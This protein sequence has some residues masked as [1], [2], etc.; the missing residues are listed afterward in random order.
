MPHIPAL[1]ARHKQRVAESF[2]NMARISLRAST[3]YCSLWIFLSWLQVV[4][5]VRE[6][7]T[8]VRSVV[9]EWFLSYFSLRIH[10]VVYFVRYRFMA[11]LHASLNSRQHFA[12]TL[13]GPR[14]FRGLLIQGRSNGT[15][16]A[17]S[18]KI[19]NALTKLSACNPH[20]VRALCMQMYRNA[21]CSI[22][23]V[24]IDWRGGNDEVFN[25]FL[26]ILFIY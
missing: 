11:N 13:Y 17:G 14:V 15:N 24:R 26:N 1:M 10:A 6:K 16:P 4:D 21:A 25:L 5:I 23:I 2:P 22:A 12:V 19:L 20:G 8:I 7:P 9:V 3:A 18:F